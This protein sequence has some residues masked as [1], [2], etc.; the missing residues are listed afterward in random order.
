MVRIET[1]EL[2]LR[3]RL[4]RACASRFGRHWHMGPVGFRA[5]TPFDALH[6]RFAEALD[7][8]DDAAVRR[9]W[10]TRRLDHVPS[11]LLCEHLS[12]GSLSRVVG[13]LDPPVVR[14]LAGAFRVPAP[15]MRATLQHVTHVRN[16]CAHHARIWGTRLGVPMPKYRSPMDLVERLESGSPRSPWRSLVLIEHLAASVP[17]GQQRDDLTT[18]FAPYDDLVLGLRGM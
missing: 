17:N 2:A 10:A 1:V 5:N 15:T 11:G 14:E 7:R 13:M 18:S 16:R 12:L 3:G 8:S 4:D 9:T 6:T